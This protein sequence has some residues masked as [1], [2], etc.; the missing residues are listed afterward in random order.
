MKLS[1]VTV[2]A[3]AALGFMVPLAGFSANRQTQAKGISDIP[4]SDGPEVGQHSGPSPKFQHYL[5]TPQ[6]Q[7]VW[8]GV[9][10]PLNSLPLM[11][12]AIAASSKSDANAVPNLAILNEPLKTTGLGPIRIGMTLDEV[13][14]TGFKLT[15][16]EGS[17][18]ECQYYRIEDYAEPIG[19]MAVD[20]RILRID[21]W[22]GSLTEALS[23]AKIGTKEQDLV[24]YYG[25]NR[26]EA[27]FN[28]NTEGKT[29]I[30]TPKDPGEDIY[31]LVF[32][33]DDHGKVVQFRA[34]QFPSV[35]WPEGCL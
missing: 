31:R 25:K 24:R 23:G 15:P 21:V 4:G 17:S 13:G 22:P 20:G 11:Q 28:A 29:I 5:Y 3:I 6:A 19:L 1:K 34:G 18:S 35:T 16:L 9:I 33:T 27:S 12:R 30:F 32:E 8:E 10:A 7:W 14:E 2:A 26:L